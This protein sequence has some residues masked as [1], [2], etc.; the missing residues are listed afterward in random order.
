MDVKR[1]FQTIRYYT[2][3]S[4]NSRGDYVRKKHIFGAVGKDVRL[5]QMVIPF[6]AENI[7][8]HNNIEIA[9]GAK[10]IPHDAIHSVFNRM[11]GNQNNFKEH[12]GKIE[13]FDNVFIGANS[14]ILGPV[15]IGPNAIVAAGAVVNKD[16]PP[17]SIVGGVPAKVIGSFDELRKK[18]WGK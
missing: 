6:R 7:I 4:S 9:S 11:D 12:E 13:I 5:P 17:N 16:V 1:F 8:L 10:M 14:L 3:F 18:R 2:F 15:A